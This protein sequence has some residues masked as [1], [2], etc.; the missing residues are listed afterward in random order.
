MVLKAAPLPS[1]IMYD[2]HDHV[3]KYVYALYAFCTSIDI[4]GGEE[5][6]P[7]FSVDVTHLGRNATCIEL[8]AAP[9]G[10][11]TPEGVKSEGGS[12]DRSTCYSR[13]R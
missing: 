8:E 10:A 7:M 12:R 13:V 9:V 2:V 3:C 6:L 5:A 11:M 1:E 4:D